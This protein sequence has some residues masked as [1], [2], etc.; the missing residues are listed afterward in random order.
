MIMQKYF[1]WTAVSLHWKK[2]KQWG[3]IIMLNKYLTTA[4]KIAIK[5]KNRYDIYIKYDII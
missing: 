5:E 4:E 1:M 3:V 2:K